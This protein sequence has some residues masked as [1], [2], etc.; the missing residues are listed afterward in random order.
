MQQTASAILRTKQDRLLSISFLRRLDRLFFCAEGC[1]QC[2]LRRGG[3][4]YVTVASLLIASVVVVYFTAVFPQVCASRPVYLF[5]RKL[6]F[7]FL[8][9]EGCWLQVV[10]SKSKATAACHLGGGLF[11][12][13]NILFNYVHC[14]TTD[15]GSTEVLDTP[16]S[17]V[18]NYPTNV[19][20][21]YFLKRNSFQQHLEYSATGL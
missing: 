19:A 18:W 10:F 16:V 7:C 5:S 9:A 4:A 13:L 15:P 21:T 11:C 2:V 12:L 14:V 6:F 20:Y 17:T 3:P 1:F 8:L